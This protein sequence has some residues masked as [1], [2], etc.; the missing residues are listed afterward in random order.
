MRDGAWDRPTPIVM[1]HEGAGIVEAVGPGVQSPR[2]GERWAMSRKLM[3]SRPSGAYWPTCRSPVSVAGSS[4]GGVQDASDRRD[5]QFKGDG[6]WHFS[7]SCR[8]QEKNNRRRRDALAA[9]HEAGAP[10]F[11]REDRRTTGSRALPNDPCDTWV[12][13]FASYIFATSMYELFIKKLVNRVVSFIQKRIGDKLDKY[14]S[15]T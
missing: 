10:C 14:S 6:D 3:N 7:P 4:R 1:G 15:K 13:F 5:L 9:L 11:G 12:E 8:G 2:V